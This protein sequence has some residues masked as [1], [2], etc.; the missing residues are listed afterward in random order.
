MVLFERYEEPLPDYDYLNL[1]NAPKKRYS[2][3][4]IFI[5]TQRAPCVVK[6]LFFLK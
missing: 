1:Q 4:K 5:C 3:I 2:R 6:T